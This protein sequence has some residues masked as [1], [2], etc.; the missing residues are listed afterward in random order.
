MSGMSAPIAGGISKP[1]PIDKKHPLP[2]S[3]PELK[4]ILIRLSD[5]IRDAYIKVSRIADS[6]PTFEPVSYATQVVSGTNY[7]VK[8]GV[9]QHGWNGKSNGGSCSGGG[10]RNYDEYIHVKIYYQPWT[11]TTELTGIA[12][13][14]TFKDPFEYD[15]PPPP[16]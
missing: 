5:R 2:K 15:L 11:K 9:T 8:L 14:K 6:A 4:K 7:Y 3:D 12:I 13:R 1:K 16:N 10:G